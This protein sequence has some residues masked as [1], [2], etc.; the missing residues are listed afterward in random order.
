MPK[1]TRVHVIRE[2]PE[3]HNGD[4]QLR[5]Q[6]CRYLHPNG[7]MQYGYRLVW[8]R[9]DGRLV[10]PRGQTRVPSLNHL[11]HLFNAARAAGWGDFNGDLMS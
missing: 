11:A 10:T 4:W 6:W 3:H 7:S 2:T 8:V 9:N 1:Q 5:L